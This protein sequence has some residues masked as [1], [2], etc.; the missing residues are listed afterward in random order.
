M[1]VLSNFLEISSEAISLVY[2]HV[3]VLK[4]NFLNILFP[5]FFIGHEIHRFFQG[6]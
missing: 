2:S 6:F 5:G 1:F 4:V 3:Q